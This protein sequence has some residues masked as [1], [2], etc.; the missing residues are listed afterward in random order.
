M[1]AA[2]GSLVA[3]SDELHARV[4]AF[5]SSDGAAEPFDALALDLARFQ[6]RHSPAF[7]RLV[8][9]HGSRLDDVASI[10]AVP[11]DAFRFTRVAVHE[12]AL[13]ECRFVTSGTTEAARGTHPFRTTA[14]Y[15][16]LATRF[17]RLALLPAGT[18][19]TVL[20]L[21]APPAS[22]PGSSL[23]FMMALFM[24][25]F[26]APG[27]SSRAERWL[28]GPSGPDVTALRRAADH[29]RPLLLLSTSLA[30]VAL[31]EALAGTKLE[32]PPQSVVMQTGGYKGRSVSIGAEELRRDAAAALGVSELAVVAE[33]GMTELTS[34][35]YEGTC[36][37]ARLDA[38]PGV[39]LPPP[40]LQVSAVDPAT[41]APVPPGEE[42]IARFVDLGNVDSAVAILTQDRVRA[43]GNGFELLGRAPGA[44]P[45]GCSLAVEALL[46]GAPG[47]ARD[48]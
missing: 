12:P 41:L 5:A 20:A 24:D 42:G 27:V 28:L 3:A 39:Y 38:P 11:T 25:A 15:R 45:R 40:W 8:A 34:Q 32:L 33:Y 23:T 16:S 17:G 30:L 47:A 22:P 26:E 1:I 44:P 18:D 2:G 36:P 48:S 31:L 43:R 13:D 19:P 4:R 29:G 37:G 21:A 35:L 14:T 10:P 46:G 9:L 7:A 6:A